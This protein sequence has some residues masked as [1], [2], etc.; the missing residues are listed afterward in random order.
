MVRALTDARTM[1]ELVR[2]R[3]K[4]KGSDVLMR[5]G[6]AVVRADRGRRKGIRGLGAL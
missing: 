4:V 6:R 5:G 2:K 1:P 3:V